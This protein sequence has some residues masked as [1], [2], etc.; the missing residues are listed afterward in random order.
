MDGGEERVIHIDIHTDD[1]EMEVGRCA[2]A[3]YVTLYM[4]TC[5]GGRGRE[6]GVVWCVAVCM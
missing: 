2:R 4:Y 3:M 6:G 1:D 5:I